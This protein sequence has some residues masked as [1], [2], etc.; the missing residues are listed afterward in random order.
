M[1]SPT[2]RPNVLVVVCDTLRPDYL[3]PYGGEFET[4]F[5]DRM[6][7]S[8]TLFE[9]AYAA[10]PG[11]SISHAA[12]F[13]GQYPSTSGV[14][15][16]VDV[17]P[18]VPRVAERFRDA[19]YDTFGMPG[20][21]RIGSHWNYDRGFDEYLEKWSDVPSSLNVN[22]LKQGLADPALLK[23]MPRE[24]VRR[25]VY[26][27][28][29]YASYLL[30]L[31]QEKVAK[32]DRPWFAFVN[33]T[34]AHSPYNPPRPYKQ[35]AVPELG[36]PRFG[37][38]D[39][40]GTEQIN[41]P[42]VSMDRVREA[43]APEGFAKSLSE[44]RY[45]SEGEREVIRSLY[46][47]S[48]R[49]LDDQLADLFEGLDAAEALDDTIIL[50]LSDHGEYLG[51]HGMTGHMFL[52]FSSCLYVPLIISGPGVP[53]GERRS[54]LASLVDVFPTLCDLVGIDCPPTVDGHSLFGERRRDAVFAENGI[55]DTPPVYGEY[56]SE[57]VRDRLERGLKS[58][59]TDDH[60]Y[61]IDSED[62]ERLYERPA[63]IEIPNPDPETLAAYR[64]RVQD[65]LGTEFPPGRQDD[66]YGEAIEENLRHLG[67]L[68]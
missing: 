16:Q 66:E 9:N 49:Y 1:P 57:E 21:S 36:R 7:D 63:E 26:G 28:D 51:E 30:D 68:S 15:G 12:L 67:Y 62:E 20:P 64:E 22:D 46:G 32:L 31:F 35:A 43:Q 10:G 53:A 48:V 45:Y 13:S 23:P 4:P 34:I 47:A 61:T 29:D 50:L 38:F 65:T 14:G 42:D 37:F 24:F 52:H 59:R 8:G 44:G 6:A 19:G 5:F 56:L 55:R 33:V 40:F 39:R 17:P 41:R 60:L 25:A 18:D 11:S 3:S 2:D 58:I 54:D 27:D